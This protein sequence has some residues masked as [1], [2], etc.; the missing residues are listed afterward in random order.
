MMECLDSFVL[1]IVNSMLMILYLVWAISVSHV[2]SGVWRE[3]GSSTLKG[4]F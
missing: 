2:V 3:R 4:I 1:V